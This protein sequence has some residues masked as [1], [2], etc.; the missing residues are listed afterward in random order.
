MFKI[1]NRQKGAITLSEMLVVVAII[2]ILATVIL[3]N[4]PVFKKQLALQRAA[5]QLAQDIR[6]AQ[7][8][9]VA[10]EECPNPPCDADE[11]PA[12]GYGIHL[13]KVP[14]PQTSYVLFADRG[15][16]PNPPPDQ[17]YGPG[18]EQIGND[19][20]FESGVKI[21]DLLDENDSST[22]HLNVIFTPP[23]PTVRLTNQNGAPGDLGK[24]ISIKICV[25][26]SQT[27]LASDPTK[28]IIINKA[29]LITV[30]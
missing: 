4:F 9:A 18:N 7:E 19:I 14:D 20:N 17:K 29:G 15:T 22:N 23:D 30:Q 24:Q 21:K 11:I 12:G 10:S 3:V 28:T 5:S 8:M 1:L 16:P 6:R 27:C 26:D 13:K 2:G 25:S